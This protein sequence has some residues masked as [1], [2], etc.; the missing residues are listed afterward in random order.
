MIHT[1]ILMLLV[2][3]MNTED[4]ALVKGGGAS[5]Q[6]A[7]WFRSPEVL[8]ETIIKTFCIN[9]E[10]NTEEGENKVSDYIYTIGTMYGNPDMGNMRTPL[11][12]PDGAYLLAL[13]I[14]SM[15]LSRELLQKQYIVQEKYRDNQDIQFTEDSACAENPKDSENNHYLFNGTRYTRH[16]IRDAATCASC[17]SDSSRAWCDCKDNVYLG[18][19]SEEISLNQAQRKRIM[20]NIQDISDFLGVP[21]DN[22][23][24]SNDGRHVPSMLLDDVFIPA[25]AAKNCSINELF[26]R[27]SDDVRVSMEDT[28]DAEGE[29]VD[30]SEEEMGEQDQQ[31]S[32]CTDFIAWQQVVH[33]LLMSGPF[34]MKL[35]TVER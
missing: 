11:Q 28:G 4:T 16:A 29:E 33:A 32:I 3:C 13:D 26:G 30:F 34:Y 15:W 35:E 7:V 2:S 31:A 1:L 23:L 24:S 21:I 18:Q 8:K 27:V 19:F 5:D 9:L 17:Y 12:E 25:L 22:E 10:G 14:V 20:H 6:N